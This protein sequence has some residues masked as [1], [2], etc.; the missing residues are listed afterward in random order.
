MEFFILE[1]FSMFLASFAYSIINDCPRSELYIAGFTGL[2]SWSIY[3]IIY[4]LSAGKYLLAYFFSSLLISIICKYLASKRM[5][6]LTIYLVPA[7]IPLVPGKTMFDTLFAFVS[8]DIVSGLE[9][10]LTT[11]TISFSI[12]VG[13]SL[14]NIVSYDFIKKI[15]KK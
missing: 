10:G 1:I 12:A 7:I 2:I 15:Q 9:L 8:K 13:I 4:I 6:P 3:L 14:S 11:F 5:N